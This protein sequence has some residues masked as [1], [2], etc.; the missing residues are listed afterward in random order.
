[1]NNDN[2]NKVRVMMRGEGKFS[3]E[4][5]EINKEITESIT[6]MHVRNYVKKLYK[7]FVLNIDTDLYIYIM[8]PDLSC[9]F[10]PTPEQKIFDLVKLFGTDN[11]LSLKISD[12]AYFG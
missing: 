6:I 9:G 10:V 2:K 3:H 8:L 4:K 7:K 12:K 1:M 11:I 5:I